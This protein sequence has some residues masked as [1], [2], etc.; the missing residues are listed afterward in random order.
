M[1]APLGVITGICS[2]TF[3]QHAFVAN[4][5]ITPL[6]LL[7]GVFYA[8]ERLEQPWRTVTRIDPIYYLVDASREGLA[9][10]HDGNIALALIVAAGV[11]AGLFA[12]AVALLCSGWRLKH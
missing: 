11:A 9:G 7:G 6:A 1:F 10:V 5:V 3:E 4:L 2:D 12:V 8:A